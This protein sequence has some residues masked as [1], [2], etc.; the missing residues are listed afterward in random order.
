[1]LRGAPQSARA[2]RLAA[3]LF[4]K[5]GQRQAGLN[6]IRFIAMGLPPRCGRLNIGEARRTGYDPDELQRESEKR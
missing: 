1:M 2:R 3:V 4:E 5:T 6:W